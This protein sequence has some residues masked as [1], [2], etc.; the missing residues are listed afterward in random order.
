LGIQ[1]EGFC[2]SNE[3]IPLDAFHDAHASQIN[4]HWISQAHFS[5]IVFTHS[6][7]GFE[8]TTSESYHMKQLFEDRFVSPSTDLQLL[9][10]HPTWLVSD[11]EFKNAYD[12][13]K[14]N[15]TAALPKVFG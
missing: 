4:L 15:I 11:V 8:D 13:I 12:D 14:S 6:Q 5:H 1:I 7:E 2:F 3:L 10:E 9:L